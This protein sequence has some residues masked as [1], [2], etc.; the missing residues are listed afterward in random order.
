MKRFT[1]IV[2]NHD[3]KTFTVEGPMAD[4]TPWIVARERQAGTRNITCFTTH[5]P[6]AEAALNYVR[7]LNYHQLPRGAILHPVMNI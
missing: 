2:A 1:L 7:Q 4:D 3:N 6:P 5:E